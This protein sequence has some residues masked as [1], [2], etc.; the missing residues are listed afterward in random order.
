M[1]QNFI[2]NDIEI[3][4]VFELDERH[5]EKKRLCVYLPKELNEKLKERIKLENK[6]FNKEISKNK[7]VLNIIQDFIKKEYE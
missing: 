1:I 2:K 5:V 6:K 4:Y 3:K 7:F